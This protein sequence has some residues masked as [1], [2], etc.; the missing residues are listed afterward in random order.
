M[1]DH[2]VYL[3]SSVVVEPLINQWYAWSFLIAP[4][5]LPMFLVN[6]HLK[7]MKSFVTAPQ[8][9]VAALRNPAMRGGP[10]L[11]CKPDKVPAIKALI[12]R[13]NR[14]CADMLEFAAAVLQLDKLLRTEAKGDTLIPLYAKVPEA[15]RG[16]VELVYDLNDQPSIRFIEG[17]LYHSRFYNPGLQA[18]LFREVNGD[19]RDFVFS[20]PRLPEADDVLLH[21]PFNAP[22]IDRLFAMRDQAAPLGPLMDELAVPEDARAKF[23]AFFTEQA[24]AAKPAP[25][26]GPGVRVRYFGHACILIETA[27]KSFLVDPVVSVRNDDDV[28]RLTLRDLP[29]TIDYVVITHAHQDHVMAETLLQIRSRVKHVVIPR[30][31]TGTL[32]DPALHLV[33][34]ELGFHNIIELGDMERLP[35]GN[36]DCLTALPFLGEHGDLDIRSKTAPHFQLAGRSIVCAAD[37]NNIE[38][39]MYEHI[40]QVVGEIDVLFIGMECVGAPLSWLYG[41]LMTKSVPRKHDQNR[42]FDGSDSA[43]AIKVVDTLRPKQV[44]VYAMGL[45]P[46]LSYLTTVDPGPETPPMVESAQLVAL[47]EQRGLTAARLFGQQVIDLSEQPALAGA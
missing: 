25:F 45:E 19:E 9:H 46:W 17:L 23:A 22:V 6:Q 14:D 7:I 26:T 31:A 36:G 33:F 16:L 34:R 37:S 28:P 39:R 15:L 21:L 40:Q 41:P 24:P 2:P 5:T 3:K 12:E 20:T 32:M 11:N 4:S 18:L 10:F 13:T 43:R 38:P 27:D 35:L 29:D 8:A 44:Y 42:R 30:G 47:C 1:Y